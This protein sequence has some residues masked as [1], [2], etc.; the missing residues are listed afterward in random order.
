MK[1]KQQL[2]NIIMDK[3]I[4]IKFEHT[5]KA[6]TRRA[7]LV[8]VNE[9]GNR[10]NLSELIDKT[11]G[12]PGSN[13]GKKASEYIVTLTEMLIDGAM[14]LEDVRSFKFDEGYKK[15]TGKETYPSSDAMGDWLRRHGGK[16]GETKL[17]SVQSE[18][19]KLNTDNNLTLDVDAT[20]IESDKGDGTFT[21]NGYRGYQPMLGM[22]ASNGLIV[23]SE[24]RYGNESPQAGLKKF[25][26]MSNE[27]VQGRIKTI[28]IDSA[29]YNSDVVNYCTDKKL[30][31]TITADQDV[32]VKAIVRNI[33]ENEWKKGKNADGSEAEW[34][35]AE[36]IHT[37]ENTSRAFRLVVKRTEYKPQ[38]NLFEPYRY[39]IVAT[40]IAEEELDANGVILF[41]QQ[42]G[43]MER[44]V[45]ELKNHFNM[46]HMPCRQFEANALYFTIG[47]LAYNLVQLIKQIA[48]G[49]SWMKKSIRSLRYQLFHLAASVIT[50]ARYIILRVACAPEYFRRLQNSFLTIRLSPT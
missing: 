27:N 41:H 18:L 10:I 46:E 6:L 43:E 31:Y 3:K 50:H 38:L 29:G 32:A 47:I 16:T 48:L 25:I 5:N 12:K 24:F 11:F 21:Y 42:R 36:T 26:E 37:M 17:W 49:S 20:I 28:R 33:G 19:L 35:V 39:W 15:L 34:E 2:A 8:I 30:K 9:F 13:S 22:I 23:G 4:R 44:L 14:Y 45:G 40:N 7:G 1:N